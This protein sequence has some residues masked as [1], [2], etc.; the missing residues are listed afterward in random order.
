MS[1]VLPGTRISE[2]AFV[3]WLVS[4]I[5]A[6]CVTI[7]CSV[8]VL[9]TAVQI[10]VEVTWYVQYYVINVVH[11]TYGVLVCIHLF[12]VCIDVALV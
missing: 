10:A 5:V 8:L 12:S 4:L 9:G 11:M 6:C 1:L 3:G 7:T 2:M